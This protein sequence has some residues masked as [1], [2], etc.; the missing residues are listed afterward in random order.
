MGLVLGDRG[1]MVVVRDNASRKSR[2]CRKKVLIVNRIVKGD[3]RCVSLE[4]LVLR[5]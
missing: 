3:E 5:Q 2:E 1:R 4:G